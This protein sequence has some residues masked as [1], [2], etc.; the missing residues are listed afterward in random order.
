MIT[1]WRE[2]SW[3]VGTVYG[4]ASKQKIVKQGRRANQIG[5]RENVRFKAAGHSYS[6]LSSSSLWYVL[7]TE[8]DS[9]R[10][11]AYCTSAVLRELGRDRRLL[12]CDAR[13]PAPL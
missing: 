7:P 8:R 11:H 9:T 10:T 12:M 13:G 3:A 6:F 2:C 4:L 1:I 5:F